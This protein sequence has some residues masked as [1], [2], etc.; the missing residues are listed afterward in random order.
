MA[1]NQWS[2]TG[3]LAEMGKTEEEKDL[4]DT[5]AKGKDEMTAIK[6]GNR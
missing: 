6:D 1:R 5:V 2:G 4:R 3:Q